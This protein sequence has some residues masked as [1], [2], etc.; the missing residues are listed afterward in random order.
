LENGEYQIM[1]LMHVAVKERE[2]ELVM[3]RQNVADVKI[4]N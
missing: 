2:K 3:C 1:G 4:E